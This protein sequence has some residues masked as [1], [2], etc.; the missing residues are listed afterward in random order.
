MRAAEP[1]VK[2]PFTLHGHPSLS[3]SNI[4]LRDT[5]INFLYIT[6]YFLN[7]SNG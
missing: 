3:F 5:Y 6:V 4:L 2:T 7:F 1:P